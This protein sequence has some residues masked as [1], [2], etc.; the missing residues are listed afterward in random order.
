MFKDNKYH[1]WYIAIIKNAESRT[2]DTYSEMHHIIPKCLGGDNSKENLVELTA[3]EHFICHWLL[4][5]FVLVDREKMDYALWLM[6][7]AENK[8]QQRYKVNSRIYDSLRTKLA[9]TFSK[10]HT[11]KKMSEETKR[12]I[13]E[14]RK[15]KFKDGSLE[16]KVY[17]TTREKLSKTRKG[18]PRSQETKD[19]I[20]KAHSGKLLSEEHKQILRDKNTGKFHSEETK[21]KISETRKQR[22]GTLNG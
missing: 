13:S 1:R 16:I 12:K 17:T 20:G 9:C 2:L 7:N 22:Y 4:T 21:R 3:R 10:Q 19:K 6:I 5:K 18:I 14:T 8:S 11:G 15:Q